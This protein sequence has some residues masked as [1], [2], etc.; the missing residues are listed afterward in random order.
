MMVAHFC[1]I[2]TSSTKI[3]LSLVPIHKWCFWLARMWNAPKQICMEHYASNYLL[4]AFKDGWWTGC[5]FC[6]FGTLWDRVSP[7]QF[8]LSQTMYSFLIKFCS[9]GFLKA[10]SSTLVF[11]TK[12]RVARNKGKFCSN[13]SSFQIWRTTINS[14]R[15][16][17]IGI[18][19]WN[20]LL[21]ECCVRSVL[22]RMHLV[23]K[24]YLFLLLDSSWS[25]FLS[26]AQS[27]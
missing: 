22:K 26:S 23:Y 3:L 11:S 4:T 25:W 24:L 17:Q 19:I 15:S 7:T 12:C 9:E 6:L 13:M 8:L 5:A 10:A 2:L 18:L 1:S 14:N 27:N 16:L 20:R 21:I